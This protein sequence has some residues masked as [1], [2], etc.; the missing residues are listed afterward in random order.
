MH[1]DTGLNFRSGLNF[2]IEYSY[3]SNCFKPD[4]DS[5][6]GIKNKYDAKFSICV[7]P[8]RWAT[9]LHGLWS[10]VHTA[11]PSRGIQGTTTRWQMI[12]WTC[13]PCCPDD[14]RGFSVARPLRVAFQH[15]HEHGNSYTARRTPATRGMGLWLVG[16][17][18]VYFCYLF[19][20]YFFISFYFCF[21]SIY[22]F[23]FLKF[24]KFKSKICSNFKNV[25]IL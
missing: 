5:S 3:S 11:M 20:V 14:C 12:G 23:F 8:W 17:F 19:F 25:Q 4:I 1:P 22:F 2:I 6:K 9:R 7:Y 24:K 16:P 18:H 13:P 21:F 15:T 10:T